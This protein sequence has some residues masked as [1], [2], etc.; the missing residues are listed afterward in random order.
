MWVWGCSTCSAFFSF[1]WRHLFEDLK[2]CWN[3]LRYSQLGSVSFLGGEGYADDVSDACASAYAMCIIP[4]DTAY[5]RCTCT[6]ALTRLRCWSFARKVPTRCSV[7]ARTRELTTTARWLAQT[8]FPQ[9]QSAH[10]SAT[11]LVLLTTPLGD[12][13]A[14]SCPFS[15]RGGK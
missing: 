9:Q 15:Q 2:K 4:C 7:R 1:V 3:L 11:L 13:R 14:L 5:T 10:L 12:S 6:S 8:R